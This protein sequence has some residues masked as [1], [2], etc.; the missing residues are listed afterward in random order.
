MFCC[1]YS[2]V[3][4][5]RRTIHYLQTHFSFSIP[6]KKERRWRLLCAFSRSSDAGGLEPPPERAR[7]PEDFRQIRRGRREAPGG[8]R[9]RRGRGPAGPLRGV[10][11]GGELL[12]RGAEAAETAFFV[13]VARSSE[14]KK[15]KRFRQKKGGRKKKEE[16]KRREQESETHVLF[17]T[18][19]SCASSGSAERAAAT[20]AATPPA[21]EGE[22]EEVVAVA[23]TE[24]GC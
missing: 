21:A 1:C 17:W 14:K 15:G 16:K 3:K 6:Q 4:R 22:G 2:L 23:V 11:M 8:S 24:V 19:E 20:A 5:R 12:P 10:G 18:A 13:V 9:E 7:P